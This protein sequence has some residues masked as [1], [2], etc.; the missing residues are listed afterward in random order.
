LIPDLLEL[1]NVAV[2]LSSPRDIHLHFSRKERISPAV[3]A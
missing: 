1:N 3:A 2:D